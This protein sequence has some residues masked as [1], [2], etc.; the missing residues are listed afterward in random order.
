MSAPRVTIRVGAAS[1]SSWDDDRQR[2]LP[3][4][5]PHPNAEQVTIALWSEGSGLRHTERMLTV[6][7]SD[8]PGLI[9]LLATY[10]AG[11]EG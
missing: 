11:E 5:P 8:V 7:R 2:T 10:L 4:D 3:I 1:A 6:T 9:A